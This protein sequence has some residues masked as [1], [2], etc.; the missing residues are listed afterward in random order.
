MMI[1]V[2]AA[3]AD[4]GPGVVGV[5]VP[6]PVR[7]H[8]PVLE[9]LP[10]TG[11]IGTTSGLPPV[12]PRTPS[13]LFLALSPKDRQA[14]LE[15][16]RP[17]ANAIGGAGK[18]DT[19][20]RFA[21]LAL[22]PDTDQVVVW[23][24]S[25]QGA[26]SLAEEAKAADP[27]FDASRVLFAHADHDLKK[28]DRVI[29]DLFDKKHNKALGH[30][31]Y[32]AA[33]ETD[34]SAIHVWTDAANVTWFSGQKFDGVPVIAEAGTAGSGLSWKWDDGRP[35]ISGDYLATDKGGCS[36]GVVASKGS[37]DYIVTAEHCAGDGAYIYGNGSTYGDLNHQSAGTYIGRASSYRNGYWDAVA[38][39]T[40][41]D[42]GAGANSDVT[43]DSYGAWTPVTS[44][45]YSWV[46]DYVCHSGVFSYYTGHGT[47][48][49]IRVTNENAYWDMVGANGQPHTTRGVWGCADN[50]W[51][52]GHGDSGALI[53]ANSGSAKQ[54][55]GSVSYGE[56]QNSN[57][58]YTCFGWTEVTDILNSFGMSLNS[59][60]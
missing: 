55:R 25:K 9:P 24:T 14:R 36:A 48:C 34:G 39:D 16:I 57:G 41:E 50:G 27:S 30:A 58:S 20:G 19:L 33:P 13:G 40:G 10:M 44:Y 15:D 2:T 5:P 17:V 60:T 37:R 28:M 18:K 54:A 59:H 3:Q 4:Q 29:E 51:G 12:K 49:G 38:I 56:T 6:A 46:S 31:L 23:A 35:Q 52:A 42:N 47:P 1:S 32:R 43:G 7:A 53:W 8:F 26:D 45:A 11:L 21:G 22:D